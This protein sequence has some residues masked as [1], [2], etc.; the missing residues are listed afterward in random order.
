M[1]SAEVQQ[2]IK[3]RPVRPEF[4]AADT[5][6]TVQRQ[7][8]KG[9]IMYAPTGDPAAMLAEDAQC[10]RYSTVDTQAR[11]LLEARVQDLNPAKQICREANFTCKSERTC[12]VRHRNDLFD[13]SDTVLDDMLILANI[14]RSTFTFLGFKANFAACTPLHLQRQPHHCAQQRIFER[15]CHT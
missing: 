14:D 8:V 7:Q 11:C 1:E 13:G 4:S 2:T 12:R 15:N 9:I 6:L 5:G 3:V 10:W